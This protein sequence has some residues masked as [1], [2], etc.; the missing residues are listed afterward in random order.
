MSRHRAS[1]VIL[2][3]R[4][5]SGSTFRPV[6]TLMVSGAPRAVAMLPGDG[7]AVLRKAFVHPLVSSRRGAVEE[8]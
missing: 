8:V 7:E 6:A 3:R 2:R 1:G 5:S 4:R